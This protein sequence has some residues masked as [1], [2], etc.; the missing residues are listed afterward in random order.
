M[1]FAVWALWTQ[2]TFVSVCPVGM[3]LPRWEAAPMRLTPYWTRAACEAAAAHFRTVDDT[4]P[5]A[6]SGGVTTWTKARYWCVLDQ[7]VG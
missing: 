7:D 1:T 4:R 6:A 2:V 3:C 5:L